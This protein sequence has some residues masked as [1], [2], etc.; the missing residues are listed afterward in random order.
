MSDAK[1]KGTPLSFDETSEF[2]QTDPDPIGKTAQSECGVNSNEGRKDVIDRLK[3]QS[4]PT[5]AS[6]LKQTCISLME[7][8]KYDVAAQK[9][10]DAYREG[11][12]G[13]DLVAKHCFDGLLGYKQ[14]LTELN[15]PYN[16]IF[17][18]GFN[19]E[20]EQ[21]DDWFEQLPQND[22]DRTVASP[23]ELY[24]SSLESALIQSMRKKDAAKA[25]LLLQCA[26]EAR[27]DK[28]S[29]L[30]TLT[31]DGEK[32]NLGELILDY[33]YEFLD[34][35]DFRQCV[36]L[37]TYLRHYKLIDCALAIQRLGCA[38]AIHKQS[39]ERIR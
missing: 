36:D 35:N 21:S 10:L 34:L 29:S 9:A 39:H 33:F 15:Q 7:E 4:V 1:I 22:K 32:V 23:K 13:C 24:S 26:F 38:M 12:K 14:Y 16:P 18:T 5:E 17:V 31:K 2:H 20:I 28:I 11:V 8:G 25:V 6:E 27:I 30:E 37:L 3:K 19:Y